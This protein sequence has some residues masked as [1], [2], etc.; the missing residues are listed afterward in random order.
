MKGPQKKDGGCHQKGKDTLDE[1]KPQ[2]KTK[3]VNV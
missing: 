2:P 1:D 3:P